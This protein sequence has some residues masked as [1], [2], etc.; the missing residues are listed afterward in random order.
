MFKNEEETKS[1]C[2]LCNQ[3][4]ECNILNPYI[5]NSFDV[6][7]SSNFLKSMCIEKNYKE[8]FLNLNK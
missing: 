5:C 3:S 6:A 1:Q 2:E 4:C 8:T 7:I